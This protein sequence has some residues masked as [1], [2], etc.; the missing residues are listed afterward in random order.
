MKALIYPSG[1]LLCLL[2]DKTIETVHEGQD[3]NLFDYC[4][5]STRLH[6]LLAVLL[7]AK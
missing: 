6:L 5:D 3:Q 4:V 1:K 7:P 2:N